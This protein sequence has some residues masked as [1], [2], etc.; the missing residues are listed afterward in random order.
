MVLYYTIFCYYI[1]QPYP[2]Y[3]T[4]IYRS[5]SSDSDEPLKRTEGPNNLATSFGSAYIRWKETDKQNST[6]EMETGRS[7]LGLILN[8]RK[9][10]VGL[11]K[12][13][14]YSL[15]PSIW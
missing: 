10:A 8:T 5:N 1:K 14:F 2:I 12:M 13:G 9:Y 7:T 3:A 4:Y 11:G 15:F 6:D